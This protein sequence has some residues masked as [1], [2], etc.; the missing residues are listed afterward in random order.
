MIDQKYEPS[1]QICAQRLF[2]YIRYSED[3]EKAKNC[4]YEALE[5]VVVVFLSYLLSYLFF[6]SKQMRENLDDRT[7]AIVSF[8]SSFFSFSLIL[9]V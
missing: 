5:Y 6:F 2:Y 7:L 4:F 8:S 3:T 1:A 9:I